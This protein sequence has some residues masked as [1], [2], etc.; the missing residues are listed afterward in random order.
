MDSVSLPSPS[1]DILVV[2]AG[3]SGLYAT[4]QLQ[5]Q[6]PG[7]SIALAERYKGLG[8][9][10]YSYWPTEPGL[11]GIH[12]EMG[13]GRIHKDHKLIMGLLKEY[14][15]TWIP[16]SSSMTYVKGP[17]SA[18]VPNLFTSVFI[19]AYIKPLLQLSLGVLAKHTIESLMKEVHGPEKTAEI[20]SYYPYR[21]E[22]NTLR[23]DMALHAFLGGEMSTD[24]DYGVIQE[25]F[26]ELITRMRAEILERGAVILNRH[27]LLNLEAAEGS[28]T[29]CHFEFGRTGH[30]EPHGFIKLRATKAVV[31]ALHK[32]AVAEL[33]IFK[34]WKVLQ[35]LQTQ[36]LLRT[37]MVF[38]SSEKHPVWFAAFQK[39]VT[40]ARPRYI[41]PIDP[42]RGV[43]MIS[44]TDG[45]DTKQ[46]MKIQS[47][48]GDNALCKTILK[49]VRTLFPD[50]KIPDPVFF[51]SHPWETGCTYWIPGSYSAEFQSKTAIHPFPSK[52]PTV[53]LCGESWS[54]RQ[55]WVEGAL[56][57]TEKMLGQIQLSG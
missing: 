44:Y 34:S 37:Y 42:K 26:S 52:L 50:C 4:R 12:W 17:G 9:R 56:E 51:K 13:A 5:R 45:D 54:L 11:K 28:S 8:G 23:A 38:K 10:T 3:I 57:Q 32:D 1:Y 40:P 19:T 36:P 29:D 24:D 22:V 31:L 20:L 25:G 41:I 14:G 46:Y 47:E 55:A 39:I 6:Y 27:R 2:G 33:P 49:D 18:P 48:K 53:W 43:I 21:A 7:L 35:Y 16:I 30:K 15:L